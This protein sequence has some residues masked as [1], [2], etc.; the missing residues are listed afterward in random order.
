MRPI[1]IDIDDVLAE[2]TRACVN[3]ARE[4][5]GREVDY[6]SIHTFDLRESF[7]FTQEELDRF[8]DAFH[9]PDVL[10]SFE[11]IPGAIPVLEDWAA[12]GIPICVVT[13]RLASSYD[14]SLEWLNRCS[15]PFDSLV[16]VDKYARL[17]VDNGGAVSLDQLSEMTFQLAIEDSLEMATFL[18]AEMGI[19][20]LL[21]DRPWNQT[22]VVDDGIRRCVD[23]PHVKEVVELILGDD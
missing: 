9:R 2:S 12:K 3:M 20:V 22:A 14:A 15:I 18:S 17:N 4:L 11:P 6:E 7:G 21:F 19:P 16:M 1:Y 8:F 5:F 13:G 23:W 10:L